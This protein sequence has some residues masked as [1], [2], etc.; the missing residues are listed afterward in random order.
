MELYWTAGLGGWLQAIGAAPSTQQYRR[1]L[2]AA[3]DNPHQFPT[4]AA[5]HP[6]CHWTSQAFHLSAKRL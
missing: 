2:S 6:E 1:L 5:C 4:E 3:T